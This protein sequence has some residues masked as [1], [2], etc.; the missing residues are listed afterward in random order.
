VRPRALT[1]L[2]GLALISA[3]SSSSNPRV[4]PTL[5]PTRNASGT[6]LS[7]A[8]PARAKSATSVGAAE[9]VRFYFETLNQA[10]RQGE[11]FPLADLSAPTCKSCA[12]FARIADKLAKAG[13]RYG[14]PTFTEIDV[15]APP[16]QHDSSFVTFTC[17]LPARDKLDS[18]GN[19]VGHYPAEK[20]L[21]MTVTTVRSG[22]GWIVKA[23]V[24]Q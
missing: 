16:L 3:C 7:V 6:T 22:D 14:G 4:L 10:Y 19:I 18:S 24:I 20:R 2:I 21:T 11:R 23:M 17:L 13:Y 1:P 9:F 12:N 8:V 15:Q 5:T